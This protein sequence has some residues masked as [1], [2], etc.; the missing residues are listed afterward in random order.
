MCDSAEHLRGCFLKIESQILVDR[1][2]QAEK[3]QWQRMLG[4]LV[5]R[6]VFCEVD[7]KLFIYLSIILTKQ[8]HDLFAYAQQI[9]K[10]IS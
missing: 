8:I 4:R 3:L 5:G 2:L 10:S 1:Q 9:N 6:Y 7:T